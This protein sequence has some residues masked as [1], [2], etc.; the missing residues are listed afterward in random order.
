[1]DDVADTVAGDGHRG[2]RR[3][4]D[5]G[6]L[7][8]LGDGRQY[9]LVQ[10]DG[11]CPAPSGVRAGEDEQAFVVP[12]HTGGEVIQLE[13][14]GQLV[15]ILLAVLQLVD[16]TQL[17]FDQSLT[18]PGEVHEHRVD[19]VPQRRLFGGQPDRLPVNL[20]ESPRDFADLLVSVDT[21]RFDRVVDVQLGGIA[22]PT[23]GLGKPVIGDVQRGGPQR[24][25]GADQ[26]AR[27]DQ[28]G[29][30]GEGQDEHD[31]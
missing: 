13:Q 27:D 19:V 29:E 15:R 20:V 5:P 31:Q 11:V 25:Q 18:A 16:E 22:Q 17:P 7:L 23:D 4:L 28:C 6:V 9:D 10:R 21:D 30:Q 2:G 3:L 8:H 24:Q 14:V 26:R 12:P 1:M